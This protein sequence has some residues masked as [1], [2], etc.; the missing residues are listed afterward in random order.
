MRWTIFFPFLL[1]FLLQINRAYQ[2][3]FLIFCLQGL[4]AVLMSLTAQ[5][6]ITN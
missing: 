3:S 4:L 1:F 2:K 5:E 6:W